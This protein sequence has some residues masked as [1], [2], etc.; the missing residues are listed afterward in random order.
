APNAVAPATVVRRP[1]GLRGHGR[2]RG[3][4]G[5]GDAG[6]DR[7]GA[8]DAWPPGAARAPRRGRGGRPVMNTDPELRERLDRAAAR[9]RI[10][11]EWRLGEIHRSAPRR[12]RIRRVGALAV[13]LVFA[14]ASVGVAWQLLRL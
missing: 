12:Q 13:A 1:G 11:T 9:V 2:V 8:P 14:L 6:W 10:D 3:G 7:A 4:P 5:A